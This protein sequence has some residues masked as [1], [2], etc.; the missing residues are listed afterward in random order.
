ME[1]RLISLHHISEDGSFINK[2]INVNDGIKY[3][4]DLILDIENSKEIREYKTISFT[5]EI[6]SIVLNLCKNYKPYGEVAAESESISNHKKNIANDIFNRIAER[7]TQCQQNA[8]HRHKGMN[9]P[10][11]GNLIQIFIERDDTYDFVISLIDSKRFIDENDLKYKSGM[12]DGKENSLKG[13]KFS[14]DKNSLE[15]VKIVLSDNSRNNISEYWYKY[16]LELD[17]VRGDIKNTTTAYNTISTIISNKLSKSFKTDYQ[18]LKNSLNTYF[19]HNDKFSYE[20][21]I[22]HLIENYKPVE[23]GWN[24]QELKEKLVEANS[25]GIFDNIFN[26]NYKDIKLKLV[27]IKYTINSNVELKI[28]KPVEK[29]SDSIYAEKLSTGEY[30]LI[31]KNV[32]N[33]ILE[34]FNFNKIEL[35]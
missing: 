26:I 19:L 10:Q 18:V 14:I 12:L 25:K 31:L 28:K 30:V 15:F 21:C 24:K 23:E 9:K 3:V 16:F 29:M 2:D 32:E 5:T 4:N 7:L 20:L 33:K 17:E 22:D 27:N 35:K 6:V 8:Q 11:K 1:I 34:K 13:A